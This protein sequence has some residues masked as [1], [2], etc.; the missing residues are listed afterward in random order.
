MP[1]GR[2]TMLY[3]ALCDDEA[4]SAREISARL[5]KELTAMKQEFDLSVFTSSRALAAQLRQGKH[6]DALFADIDMPELDGIK[7]G[8]LYRTELQDTVLVYISNRE[9]LVFESFQAKPFRFVRKKRL[10][11]LPSVL[12]DVLNELRER[13][14]KKIAFP[15]GANNTV[16]LRPERISYVEALKKKQLVHCDANVYE[17]SSSFQSI[18]E[19]LAEYGFVQTHKSFL[20]NCS[21]IHAIEKTEITLDNGDRIPVSRSFLKQVQDAFVQYSIRLRSAT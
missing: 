12:Q 13:E 20:V 18:I 21:Y 15:C 10:A 19:Q 7:L 5:R 1:E 14:K 9:D 6:F 4:A 17:I 3:F 2:Q 8:T 11:A 16:L